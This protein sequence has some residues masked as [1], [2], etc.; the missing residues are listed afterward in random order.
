MCHLNKGLFVCFQFLIAISSLEEL[1]VGTAA[2][3][4]EEVN[5]PS[6]LSMLDVIQSN[7]AKKSASH[8]WAEWAE[9]L[10]SHDTVYLIRGAFEETIFCSF[11]FQSFFL[12]PGQSVQKAEIGN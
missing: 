9:L 11:M 6:V 8:M 4:L 5:T 12:H 1:C 3:L 7:E 2:F 10:S